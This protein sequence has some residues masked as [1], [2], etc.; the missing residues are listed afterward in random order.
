MK[1][2]QI[3]TGLGKI[4]LSMQPRFSNRCSI[5]WFEHHFPLNEF[6]KHLIASRMHYGMS[7]R[8]ITSLVSDIKDKKYQVHTWGAKG[9]IQVFF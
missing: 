8:D 7:M 6:K 1:E 9:C 2:I 4:W 3:N 5:D